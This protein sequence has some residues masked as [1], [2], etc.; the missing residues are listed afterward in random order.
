V[1]SIPV[2]Y[3]FRRCPYAIRA[4]MAL[5]Y[6]GVAYAPVEVD[7]KHKPEA[8]LRHSPKGTVPVMVLADGRVLEESLDI[9]RYA[10]SLA[11]PEGWQHPEA[12]ALIRQHDER[13]KPLLDRY[14]YHIRHPELPR[15]AHQQA[16]EVFLGFLEEKLAHNPYLI[17]PRPTLADAAILPFVRQWHGV[18]GQSLPCFPA[19][20]GW[21]QQ[22]THFPWFT[23]AMGALPPAQLA[24]QNHG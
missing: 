17:A 19:L 1:V 11:D 3:T 5:H 8:L 12:E 7:L 13:F 18:D 6:A 14:K 16:G 20:W 23:Q 22:M 15:E 10:L 4:R 21:F 2:L 24:P 9:M